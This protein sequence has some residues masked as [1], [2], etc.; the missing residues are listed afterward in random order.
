MMNNQTIGV[1]FGVGMLLLIVMFIPWFVAS[2]RKIK[3]TLGIFL[4]CLF[5]GWTM[6]GWVGA[7]IWSV[8]ENPVKKED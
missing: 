5:L 1:L 8:V 7:L 3:N 2:S 6:L 4:L